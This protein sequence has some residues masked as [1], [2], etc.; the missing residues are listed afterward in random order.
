MLVFL[1]YMLVASRAKQL[2]Q[3][4]ENQKI[5]NKFSSITFIGFGA[6]LG[7]SDDKI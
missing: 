5:F 6:A 3:S 7:V 4:E 2:V 1:F